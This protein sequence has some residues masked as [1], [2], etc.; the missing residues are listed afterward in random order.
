MSSYN[1]IVSIIMTNNAEV[2]IIH[3]YKS[4]VSLVTVNIKYK[5]LT[6]LLHS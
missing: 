4:A 3:W 2:E 5:T 1:A 6:M